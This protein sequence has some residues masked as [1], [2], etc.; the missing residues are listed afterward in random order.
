MLRLAG[1][2][3][4]YCQVPLTLATMTLDHYVPRALGGGDEES[5][6]MVACFTC[7]VLKGDTHPDDLDPLFYVTKPEVMAV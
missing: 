6:L 1:H 5:N 3:C 2:K 7:N 4:S